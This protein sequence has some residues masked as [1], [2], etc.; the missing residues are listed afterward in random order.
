MKQPLRNRGYINVTLGV[1]KQD[2]Q[3]N[4]KLY[5]EHDYWNYLTLSP[6]SYIDKLFSSGKSGKH[7]TATYE[8][9]LL[10]LQVIC[11]LQVTT[12]FLLK[13]MGW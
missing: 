7:D 11:T 3:R 9:I 10:Q 2:A 5:L 13:K 6:L 1:I 4:A 8:K 12:S